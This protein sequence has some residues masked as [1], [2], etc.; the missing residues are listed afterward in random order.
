MGN[1]KALWGRP[2]TASKKGDPHGLTEAQ[3]IC[4]FFQVCGSLLSDGKQSFDLRQFHFGQV[5]HEDNILINPP[6]FGMYSVDA[7]NMP[8]GVISV[9]LIE[10]DGTFK[11]DKEEEDEGPPPSVF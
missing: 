9:P 5:F 2:H 4:G 7:E 1:E 10:E 8:V 3:L 11:L 6:T